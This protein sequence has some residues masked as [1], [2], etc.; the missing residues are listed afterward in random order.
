[1]TLYGLTEQKKCSICGREESL[2]AVP[3][4][5]V[6]S[7]PPKA[8]TVPVTPNDNANAFYLYACD[9]C[10]REKGQAPTKARIW[11]LI[12]YA[13]FVFGVVMTTDMHAFGLENSSPLPMIPLCAGLLIY[14]IAG[15][16]LVNKTRILLS[17]GRLVLHICLQF[18]PLIGLLSLLILHGKINRCARAMTALKPTADEYMQKEKAKNDELKQLSESGQELSEADRKRVAQ[19]K[20]ETEEKEQAAE[21]IRQEQEEKAN[22]SNFRGAIIGIIF[23][24]IIGIVGFST[25]D[26]GRGYMTF[27]G[28]ELSSGAF[29]GLI[30]LFLAG[31]IVSLVSAIKKRNQ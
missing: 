4:Y 18:I 23:T 17:N 21:T 31:D 9:D 19:Y 14:M 24:V 6:S 10:G 13:L 3:F 27:F 26:S 2:I 20:K 1:M 15:I 16:V 12:G 7:D 22:R 29:T 28:I 30:G 8:I 5:P 25:Y 11:L